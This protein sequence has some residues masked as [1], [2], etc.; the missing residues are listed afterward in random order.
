VKHSRHKGFRVIRDRL[1]YGRKT[2]YEWSHRERKRGR[3]LR[4]TLG[5]M[6][7][8]EWVAE[9][10]PGSATIL[11]VRCKGVRDGKPI[12]VDAVGRRP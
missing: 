6:P 10:W 1:T 11:A 9:N 2:P 3:D 12:D 7:A 8:P 5:G 4:W